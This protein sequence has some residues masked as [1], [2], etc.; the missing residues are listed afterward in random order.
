MLIDGIEDGTQN[1]YKNHRK[2]V[3]IFL[4]NIRILHSNA[5]D[6]KEYSLSY[7]AESHK[8][9]NHGGLILIAQKFIRFDSMLMSLCHQEMTEKLMHDIV[10]KSLFFE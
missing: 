3:T 5:I 8:M 7:Y 2:D 1:A 10:G 9:L 6:N 4:K